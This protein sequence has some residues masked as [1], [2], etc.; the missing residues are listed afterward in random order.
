[1]V[2]RLG[3]AIAT[4][5]DPD[6]LIVD[7]ALSVGDQKF[8][9]KCID[10]M[11]KIKESGT[12]IVFC[13]HSMYMVNE[14][15]N[16]CIWLKQGKIQEIGVTEDVVSSYLGYIDENITIAEQEKHNNDIIMPEVVI[17][18]IELYDNTHKKI[19]KIRQF[20]PLY[21][22]VHTTCLQQ[23][24]EGHLAIVLEDQQGTS[25]FA[26]LTRSYT[27]KL[28]YNET[29]IINLYI[30]NICLQR[31]S[32]WIKAIISDS[33]ALRVIDEKRIGPMTIVSKN[34]EYG[35]IW[36]EHEWIV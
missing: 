23:S 35:L 16:E 31:G 4:C 8:Q 33:H 29:N 15:C 34:P 13:S 1:M 12:T 9:E 17:D 26:A 25:Y 7:E 22:T 30:P 18:D 24:F 27:N 10:R 2:V 5:V 3:F 32:I 36:M 14:L 6:I 21:I 20:K 19:Q 28:V 11:K